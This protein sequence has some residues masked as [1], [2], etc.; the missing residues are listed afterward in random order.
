VVLRKDSLPHGRLLPREIKDLADMES[1]CEMSAFD[2][3]VPKT[4]PSTFHRS[5]PFPL[6]EADAKNCLPE[7]DPIA[8]SFEFGYGAP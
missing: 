4:Y 2:S 6:V 7:R 3:G 8:V 1:C 5:R